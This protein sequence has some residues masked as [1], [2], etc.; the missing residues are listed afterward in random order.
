MS[1]E[2]QRAPRRPAEDSSARSG[3]EGR[4]APR[5][6]GPESRPPRLSWRFVMYLVL[7]GGLLL[8]FSRGGG[9]AAG[10]DGDG[11]GPG[12]DAGCPRTGASPGVSG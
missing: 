9:V 1:E 6:G 8:I 7:L 10:E 2:E 11:D 5:S 3:E 4:R 12:A